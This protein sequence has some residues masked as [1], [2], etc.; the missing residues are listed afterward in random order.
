MREFHGWIEDHRRTI[1]TLKTIEIRKILSGNVKIYQNYNEKP[2]DVVKFLGEISN[3]MSR[4]AVLKVENV[5]DIKSGKLIR[6]CDNRNDYLSICL[7]LIL[8]SFLVLKITR[9]CLLIQ[10]C[11]KIYPTFWKIEM[12]FVKLNC[13]ILVNAEDDLSDIFETI[14]SEINLLLKQNTKT[15][16][17]ISTLKIQ[18]IILKGLREL[19]LQKPHGAEHIM[20]LVVRNRA[21]NRRLNET[22]EN[23]LKVY[24]TIDGVFWKTIEH[25]GASATI[26]KEIGLIQDEPD[27][28]E[29]FY[30]LCCDIIMKFRIESMD[31]SGNYFNIDRLIDSLAK[32]LR[33]VKISSNLYKRITNEIIQLMQSSSS[34]FKFTEKYIFRTI[35]SLRVT[36]IWM[37]WIC[38]D[39]FFKILNT[40]SSKKSLESYQKILMQ[41][42]EK[43]STSTERSNEILICNL[44]SYNDCLL[45][46]IQSKLG[47]EHKS[48]QDFINTYDLFEQSPS[49]GT[50]Y[51]LVNSLSVLGQLE[52]NGDNKKIEENI[53]ELLSSSNFWTFDD[54]MTCSLLKIVTSTKNQ[55]VKTRFFLMLIPSIT[56]IRISMSAGVEFYYT[57]M[58]LSFVGMPWSQPAGR[59]VIETELRKLSEH[60]WDST[61]KFLAIEMSQNSGL[62]QFID[63]MIENDEYSTPPDFKM[64]QMEIDENEVSQRIHDMMKFSYSLKNE[65]LNSSDLTKVK[66][67]CKNLQHFLRQ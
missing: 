34:N 24:E 46:L 12:Q 32:D 18:S 60:G 61:K 58:L 54:D 15:A 62:R 5:Q 53:C 8:V 44:I 39:I 43:L 6:T 31:R 23:V 22:D 56:S 47:I 30:E 21:Y 26:F 64:E 11:L 59:I 38:S 35:F 65:Q 7:I 9:E 57:K 42:K 40:I 14:C 36:N 25:K 49:P 16:E 28:I 13:S 52:F 29:S 63:S 51:K 10:N 19:F 1:S 55:T 41:V 4:L 66:I 17:Q 50:F 3:N 27:V 45:K 2:G 37:R 20:H 48:Q 67:I 33:I